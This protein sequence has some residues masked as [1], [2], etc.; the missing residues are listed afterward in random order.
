MKAMI[1]AAGRGERM[2]PLTDDCPKPLLQ[3][4]GRSLLEWHLIALARAGF[5]Q[6]IINYA[7]QGAKIPAA[8]GDGARYGLALHYS[9]EGDQP[10]ET[11][12]GIFKVLSFFEGGN[13]VVIN[14][15]IWTDFN[16]KNLPNLDAHAKAALILVPN[17]PQ[18]PQGDFVLQHLLNAQGE[19]IA[20]VVTEQ[21]GSPRYTFSGIAVYNKNFFTDCKAGKFP[22]SPLL[23]AAACSGNVR[24]QLYQGLW[25]DIGTPERLKELDLRLA[26]GA[27]S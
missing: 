16:F 4:G 20:N 17:P 11:A 15:D 27:I 6:V 14:G 12:G 21:Q 2:R 8:L 24:G 7:W 13:F 26:G 1:L 10:L 25:H 3:V 18:H 22:L 9:D 23:Q 5:R 19:A